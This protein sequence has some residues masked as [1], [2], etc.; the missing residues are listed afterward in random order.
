MKDRYLKMTVAALS[1]CMAQSARTQ[2][3]GCVSSV[4]SL[5]NR[6]VPQASHTPLST[7]ASLISSPAT[8]RDHVFLAHTK[9]VIYM[10]RDLF[11]LLRGREEGDGGGGDLYTQETKQEGEK[12]QNK[13]KGFYCD[14]W[15]RKRFNAGQRC[16]GN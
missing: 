13:R 12:R 7:H 11:T 10:T 1:V 8:D 2:T 15:R 9:Q 5:I 6:D 16:A 14:G 4:S 3:C